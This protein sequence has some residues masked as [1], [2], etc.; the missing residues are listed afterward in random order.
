M[1]AELPAGKQKADWRQNMNTSKTSDKIWNAAF[2]SIFLANA[3]MNLGQQMVNTLV[4]KYADYLGAAAT[5]VGFLS[6]LF[7]ATA[8][9]FKIVSGPAIDSFSRKKILMGAMT[10]MIISYIGFGISTSVP[11]LIGFRLLEGVAR[12][13]TATCS[14]AIASDTLPPSK[15]GSGIGI[16]SLAQAACQAIG[17]TVGLT[18]YRYIGYNATFFLAAACVVG[19]VIAAANMKLEERPDRKKFKISL[20]NVAASEAAVPAVLLFLLAGTFFTINSFL[21]IYGT[22]MGVVNIGFFFTVYA[23][24]MLVSRPLIGRLSDKYGLV[25]VTIPAIFCF[26]LS[27]YLISIAT[28]LPMFLIAAFVAAFGYGAAQPAIQT[29]CM[30]SVPPE[31]RGAGSNTAYIG[32]D[33]G[34][35][36]GPVVAG[37][38]AEAAGYRAMW[39]YMIIPMAVALVIMLVFSNRIGTIESEFKKRGN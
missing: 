23:G 4:A 19:G 31:R 25:K 37:M 14:L 39:R 28:G 2:I 18:L 1:C 35:M 29:L 26:A 8:L 5:L 24:V 22:D 27:F 9:L 12:A 11:M 20:S 16:F 34:N 33:L 6:G 7:A 21:A 32:N 3:L 13:F 36:V 15:F 38:I 17:P 30:K 10:I